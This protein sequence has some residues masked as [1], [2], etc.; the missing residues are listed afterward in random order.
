MISNPFPEPLPLS[1]PAVLFELRDAFD[2]RLT[3]L[4][5]QVD[6]KLCE[7]PARSVDHTMHVS[8]VHDGLH[9]TAVYHCGQERFTQLVARDADGIDEE[10]PGYTLS[11]FL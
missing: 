4:Q 1:A 9:V 5:H 8:F 6:A 3:E 2:A 11:M 10:R 7:E